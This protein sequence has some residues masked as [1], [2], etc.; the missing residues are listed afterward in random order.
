VS[1]KYNVSIKN[2]S[3]TD[4]KTGE[5]LSFEKSRENSELILKIGDEDEFIVGDKTY[6]IK[7][8]Y[9][10]GNDGIPQF[11]ELYYN[12]IGNGWDA[13]IENATFSI[14][15]PKEFD[16][17]KLNFT[18]GRY[19][20]TD[21]SSVTYQVT[22]NKISGKVNRT[23]G[24]GEGFTVRLE[25]PDKYFAVA[26]QGA[27]Y[28][29]IVF[30]TGAL[31]I[32][33]FLFLRYGRD[34]RIYE[35]VEVSPPNDLIPAE[36]GYIIDG[37]VDNRDVL[38]LIIY[39]ADKGYLSIT[40]NDNEDFILTK[41]RDADGLMKSYEVTMFNK[42]FE[43]LNS[44]TI[45]N[46]K[47]KFNTTI[48]EVKNKIASSYK[49]PDKRLFTASGTFAKMLC[50]IFAGVCMGLI[51]G[52]AVGDYNFDAGIG[53]LAGAGSAVATIMLA[54]IIGYCVD[55]S[56]SDSWAGVFI[57][58]F[59]YALC[60]LIATAVAITF[61]KISTEFIYGAAVAFLCGLIG[62]FAKKRTPHSNLWL[63][64]LL[65]LKRFITLVEKSRIESMVRENPSLFYSILPYAYALGV[66]DQWAKQFEGLA[67]EP[68][69]WYSSYNNNAFTMIYFTSLINRNMRAYETSMT[70]VEPKGGGSAGGGSFGGGGFSGGGFGG[71]GGGSW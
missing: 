39:W 46:L 6:V 34:D 26:E 48:A 63:G 70:S 44:V 57:T 68:P 32:S 31:I 33:I 55:K 18:C 62:S 8:S 19:G 9:G 14:E 41:V 16:E 29:L 40:S 7:Y 4:G 15:M 45:D 27:N 13:D 22:G 21:S 23:L 28:G 64:K 10:I 54:S 53:F 69:N 59:L 56:K 36:A 1:R 42:L 17:N 49:S 51:V 60:I 37:H 66:T 61:S 67:I 43:E 25:L 30:F 38:S 20:A 65:G 5:P 12:L 50:Y 35:S 52:K 3:V 24:S 58:S 71:G 11:D 47:Y 2:I